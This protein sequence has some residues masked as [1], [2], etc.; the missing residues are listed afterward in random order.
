M[1]SQKTLTI[2]PGQWSSEAA[3][4]LQKALVHASTND[5]FWQVENGASLFYVKNQDKVIG[6]YVLR[7]DE[8]ISGREG[9]IVAASGNHCGID[10]VGCL[11]PHMEAQFND[12]RSI[13]IHTSRTGM[14][15][16]LNQHGYRA[17]EIVFEKV[18]NAS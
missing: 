4:F 3:D 17:K 13:R 16:K 6:C 1:D 10:L 2:E 7:I 11:L 14:A 15:Y 8:T 18:L 12:V 5:I 9:V